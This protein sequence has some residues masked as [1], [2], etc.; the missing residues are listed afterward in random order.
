MSRPRAVA[1][2]VLAALALGVAAWWRWPSSRPAL[3]CAGAQ[4]VL[5]EQGVVRCAAPGVVGRPLPAGQ[6][7]T[8][9][10]RL[11]LNS[12]TADELA[13][14]PGVGAELATALVAER[15]RLG[16][17]FRGWDEVDAVR[18]VGP[19]RLESLKDL[20]EIRETDSGVW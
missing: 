11:D 2:V 3:D 16:G 17:R 19:A 5:D 20:S 1:L 7:L 13:V 9:G 6:V 18:G 12:A 10:R 4:L 8:V 14:I 15:S